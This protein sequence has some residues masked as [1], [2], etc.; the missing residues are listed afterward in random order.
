MT[1]TEIIKDYLIKDSN[2]LAQIIEE[3]PFQIPV[4]VIAEWWHCSGDSIRN[5]LIQHGF[6]GIAQ[7]QPGKVNAGFVIPTGHFVRWWCCMFGVQ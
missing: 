3:Y 2:K 7:K 1:G 6:L 4:K 5:A